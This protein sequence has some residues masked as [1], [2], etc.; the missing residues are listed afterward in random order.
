MLLLN[1]V[2][3]ELDD[4][5]E[6]LN[7]I[8]AKIL[9][10]DVVNI[11][12]AK[13]NKRSLDCRKKNDIHY[14]C[15][16]LVNVNGDESR[17]LKIKNVSV[18][19]QK[20]YTYLKCKKSA[21]SPVVVG[22]GPAGMFAALT[23]AKAGLKPIVI[24]RGSC[25]E[26]RLKDVEL[27]FS[28]GKL[29]E[30]SNI[31]FGEGGAGTFSDGKLNTGIKD[32][33]C[34]LVLEEFVN[35]G[36]ADKIL[37]DAKPHI[38]TDVLVKVV[39]NIREQIISLGG[40]VLFNTK[41]CDIL[42]TDSVL[43]GITVENNGKT[44][45][46]NCE[47]LILSI[48]HSARDTFKMLTEKPDI[49]LTRKPF[50]MGVRI[51]H[52]QEVINKAQYGQMYNNP[53]LPPADYKLA[54]HLNNGR[55]VYTFCMCPGGVVVNAASEPDTF[56]TNGM[57]YSLRDGK[58][59]NS[60]LLVSVLESD[61]EGDD[62]LCGMRLQEKVEKAAFGKT[63]G[64]GA[65]VQLVGDF[66]NKRASLKLGGVTPTIKPNFTLCD[67][68]GIYPSFITE[69]LR[70]AIPL[71]AKK[72]RDFDLPDAVIT[73]PETRSTCPVRIIR[74]D[75]SYEA[76]LHGLYPAGEGA[77]YAGGIMSAAV[78]GIKV[79]EAVINAVNL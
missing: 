15:S 10:T 11:I 3:L 16:V 74:N 13:L 62:I 52:P 50:S 72:L 65:P 77:G 60:A 53:N 54:V 45:N 48:G 69:S 44:Y 12:S 5:F 40:K 76:S 9:K 38:G 79:A 46:I 73:A 1:N 75:E 55:G 26:E 47:K 59:A 35:F 70:E 51:E 4:S 36:A 33:R 37:Y 63:N 61:L 41:L 17:F 20:P 43:N 29:N 31:Q 8:A 67:I 18:F 27:L 32:F 39:K 25:V 2:R 30:N 22:F 21:P 34:R 14:I 58:N 68:D 24:E 7:I 71:F 56:V 42:T 49:T 64:Q 6:N 28:G 23:L 57:S 66:L 19:S 78:D